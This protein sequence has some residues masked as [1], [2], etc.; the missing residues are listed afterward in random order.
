MTNRS[1]QLRELAE[2][3]SEL[4]TALHGFVLAGCPVCNGDCASASP[5]V[6]GC[7]VRRSNEAVRKW[8]KALR[9][10]STQEGAEQ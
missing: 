1:E 2:A 3:G 5:P 7:P 4:V 10:Q 9:S 8:N 6:S